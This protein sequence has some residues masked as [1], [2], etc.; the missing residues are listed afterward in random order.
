[1]SNAKALVDL[2]AMVKTLQGVEGLGVRAAPAVADVLRQRITESIE[3]GRTPYGEEWKLV[4]SGPREGEKALRNAAKALT[5]KADGAVVFCKLSGIDGRHSKGAVKGKVK[6]LAVPDKRGLP[7]RWV[8]DVRAAIDR[9]F[10]E[11]VEAKG[12]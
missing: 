12:Q 7:H 10:Q 5:V 1:M 4:Q 11:I 3:A 6:R 2:D 8:P 9:T